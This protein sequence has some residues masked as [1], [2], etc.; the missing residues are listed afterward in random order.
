MLFLNVYFRAKVLKV[1]KTLVQNKVQFDSSHILNP[2]KMELEILPKYPKHREDILTF[3]SHI[4]FSIR[5][6]CILIVLITIAGLILK[7]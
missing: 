5:I 4:K 6:A 3:V 1:Y 2:K 7:R